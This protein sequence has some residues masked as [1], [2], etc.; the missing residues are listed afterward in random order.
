M[1]EPVEVIPLSGFDPEGDP[2]IRRMADGRLWLVFNFMPPSWIPESEYAD[3]G[4]CHDFDRRLEAALG[5]PVTWEDR[6]FFRVDQPRPDTVE[7]VKRFLAE[8]RRRHDQ[9][10]PAGPPA[11]A[12]RPRH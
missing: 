9:G 5:V 3:M 4:R 6:E 10:G 12:D 7:R 1:E 11:A 8:F 2:E